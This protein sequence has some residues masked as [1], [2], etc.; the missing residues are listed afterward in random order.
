MDVIAASAVSGSRVIG[1]RTVC[2]GAVKG[3]VGPGVLYTV[4]RMSSS[5]AIRNGQEPMYLLCNGF[6]S[7]VP[8]G[9]VVRSGGAVTGD[10]SPFSRGMV[11]SATLEGTGAVP[12]VGVL[13][14]R[15]IMAQG[16]PVLGSSIIELMGG[17]GLQCDAVTTV[18]VRVPTVEVSA[19]SFFALV[20]VVVSGGRAGEVEPLF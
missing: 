5:H 1:T 8:V 17:T 9:A 2:D 16:V 3:R 15:D 18:D 4:F 13:V 20:M 7:A 19:A 14:L 6:N 12:V 11:A 10:F